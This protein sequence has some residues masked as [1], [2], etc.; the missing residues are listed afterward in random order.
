M[1][2]HSLCTKE[3]THPDGMDFLVI[4]SPVSSHYFTAL[5]ALDVSI[6]EPS[7]SRT[8][9][10]SSASRLSASRKSKRPR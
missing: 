8:D 1:S 9:I 3:K 5:E 4:L 10:T 2:I 7:F 6:P